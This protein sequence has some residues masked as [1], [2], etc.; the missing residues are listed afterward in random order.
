MKTIKQ[1]ADEIG[2][3]KTAIRKHLTPEVRTKFAQ[4]VSG[5][6]QITEDG[7]AFIKQAFAEKRPQT[8]FAAN[9]ANGAHPV[10]GEVSAKLLDMLQQELAGKDLIIREQQQQMKELT[11]ALENT[12]ASLHAAQALHAGTMQKQIADGNT[13][14]VTNKAENKPTRRGLFGL[15]RGR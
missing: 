13:E 6:I 15:F 11:A 12:T 9:S 7:E 1:L 3:S 2:V 4:T 8:K 14:D 10:S 5:T